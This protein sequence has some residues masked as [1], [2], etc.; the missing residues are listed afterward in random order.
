M[1]ASKADRRLWSPD[2]KA[3]ADLAHLKEVCEKDLNEKL[4]KNVLL[5]R[6]VS[7]Y[8]EMVDSLLA[9]DG[10]LGVERL[11]LRMA[12]EGRSASLNNNPTKTKGVTDER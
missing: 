11:R 2:P 12:A 4:S 9:K 7:A 8:R 6:A 5:R 10:F 3:K 1:R